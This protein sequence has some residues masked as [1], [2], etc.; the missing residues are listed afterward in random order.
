VSDAPHGHVPGHATGFRW[1]D[2]VAWLVEVHGSLAAVAE[3][4]AAH[5]AWSDDRATIERG[6]RRLRTRADREGGTWG[7]RCLQV[8]G[9]PGALR[10]RL[11][12][13][14]AYHSRFTDLPV[15]VC[16][17]LLRVWDTAPVVDSAEAQTWLAL[18]HASCALR[19]ARPDLAA[20]QLRKARAASRQA[21]PDARAELAL[22][23]AYAASRDD[24]ARVDA[25]LD[26]AEAQLAD[27]TDDAARQCLRARL[28]DQHAWQWNKGRR[29]TAPDFARAEALYVT[30]DDDGAPPFARCRRANGLAY[31]AWKR[32]RGEEAVG[33]A[34]AAC[35]HAGDGGHLRLRAMSLQM[36]ARVGG[37]AEAAAALARAKDIA[38]QLDDETLRLRFARGR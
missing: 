16:E 17:D 21:P 3:R 36:L 1:D 6:L 30:L 12:W 8:F 24:P 35:E 27:V 20:P 29:G 37:G 5:R 26:E 7:D 28:I 25:L 10:A 23:E 31:G 4:L 19:S 22:T 11:R 32:G 18:A 34:R 13:L 33:Y 15:P 9:L 2:Y 38:A 14:G